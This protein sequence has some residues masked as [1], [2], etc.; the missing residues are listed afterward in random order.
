VINSAEKD[1]EGAKNSLENNDIKNSVLLINQSSR[2]V[3]EA[4]I[5]NKAEKKLKLKVFESEDKERE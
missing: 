5:I 3:R 2:K 1:V 4:E